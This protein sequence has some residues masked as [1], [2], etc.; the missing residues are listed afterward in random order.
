MFFIQTALAC[1]QPQTCWTQKQLNTAPAVVL[2]VLMTPFFPHISNH[3]LTRLRSISQIYYPSCKWWDSGSILIS[4][5]FQTHTYFM[6]FLN[7]S[8]LSLRPLLTSTNTDKHSRGATACWLCVTKTASETVRL[9]GLMW[10]LV[11]VV[12]LSP[13]SG[14]F[15]CLYVASGHLCHTIHLSVCLSL[16]LCLFVRLPLS[17]WVCILDA[18]VFPSS[19]SSSSS[20]FSSSHPVSSHSGTYR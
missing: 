20:S 14:C 6:L 10:S 16:C 8:P 19:C 9:R 15:M 3:L 5:P 13:P 17:V 1:I 4:W 11:P 7:L 12:F 2:D 18:A